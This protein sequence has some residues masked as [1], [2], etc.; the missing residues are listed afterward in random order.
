MA[1]ILSQ[2]EICDAKDLAILSCTPRKARNCSL[3]TL[4]GLLKS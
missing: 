1:D 4:F 3:D 2:E